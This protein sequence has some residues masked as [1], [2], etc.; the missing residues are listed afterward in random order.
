LEQ[1]ITAIVFLVGCLLLCLCLGGVFTPSNR[2][3][4]QNAANT[5]ERL[6]QHV[7]QMIEN[8]EFR[9]IRSVVLVKKSGSEWEGIVYAADGREASVHVVCDRDNVLAT[10]LWHTPPFR[11]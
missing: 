10:W 6:E 3:P 1:A 7:R 2:T 9:A 4:E 8:K 11:F 5:K